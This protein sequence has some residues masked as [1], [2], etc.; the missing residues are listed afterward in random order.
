MPEHTDYLTR[1]E[2]AQVVGVH[3]R[4]LDH[5]AAR[6]LGPR[7]I[8]QGPRRVRYHRAEVARWLREGDSPDWPPADAR[9]GPEA[10]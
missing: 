8:K 1:D 2:L 7:P 10:A 6:G 3:R 9:N 5:W 4:T